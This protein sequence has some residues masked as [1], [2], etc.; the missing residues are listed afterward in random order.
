MHFFYSSKY[1]RIYFKR[2][3]F[4]GYSDS[5][6][7]LHTCYVKLSPTYGQFNNFQFSNLRSQAHRHKHTDYRVQL[8]INVQYTQM[9]NINENIIYIL[10]LHTCLTNT[11]LFVHII[12][13]FSFLISISFWCRD[14]SKD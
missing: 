14:C 8:V 12:F 5:F 7:I 2:D 10:F 9:E 4:S 11:T 3:F 6:N 1:Y 13:Q